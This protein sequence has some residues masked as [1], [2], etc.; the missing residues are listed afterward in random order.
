MAKKKRAL[1]C[2]LLLRLSVGSG[3]KRVKVMRRRRKR[4]KGR[5][6]GTTENCGNYGVGFD[7]WDYS[8]LAW[9]L[10]KTARTAG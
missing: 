8:L 4:K 2:F 5:K 3:P 6:R 10:T 1:I 7:R 9:H